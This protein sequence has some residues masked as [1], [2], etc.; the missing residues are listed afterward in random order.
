MAHSPAASS[1]SSREWCGACKPDQV[2]VCQEGGPCES[3]RC[4]FRVGRVLE[5]TGEWLGGVKTLRT[6][7]NLETIE[8]RARC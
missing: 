6:K 8:W 5:R 4:H 3:V 1:G 2:W 7:T